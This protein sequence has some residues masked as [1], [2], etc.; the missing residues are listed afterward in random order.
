MNSRIH[1]FCQR[2]ID[3]ASP[4]R[5]LGQCWICWSIK[6]CAW[7]LFLGWR[8]CGCLQLHLPILAI[9]PLFNLFEA[10]AL[11]ANWIVVQ[12]DAILDLVSMRTKKGIKK[13]RFSQVTIIMPWDMFDTWKLKR[14]REIKGF[15]WSQM[16]MRTEKKEGKYFLKEKNNRN[17]GV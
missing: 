14:K 10:V 13:C 7:E 9:T 3:I 5:R 8:W 15:V 16:R 1:V 12:R 4:D 6:A 17:P 2:N 11:H